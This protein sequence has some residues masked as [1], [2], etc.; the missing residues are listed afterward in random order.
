MDSSKYI[1]LRLPKGTGGGEGDGLVVWDQHIHTE[2][3][4]MIGRWGPAI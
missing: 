1:R 4:R 3:H 2:V